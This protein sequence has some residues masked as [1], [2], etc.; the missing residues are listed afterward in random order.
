[1]TNSAA[2]LLLADPK[3][4]GMSREKWTE[5][6]WIW[7]LSIPKSVNP[8]NDM[9]GD[10]CAR[11]QIEP[12]MWFLAG[13][14]GKLVKR[15]CLVPSN[16]AILFPIINSVHLLS[17][18]LSFKSDSDLEA[19][20]RKEADNVTEMNLTIDGLQLS[21]LIKYRIHTRSFDI[22]I[23]EDNICGVKPGESR[24]AAD[25]YWIF[26]RPLS[27]GRHTIEFFGKDLDLFETGVT[28]ELTV[29]NH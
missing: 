12:N 5:K 8:A 22:I 24:A 23:P 27:P 20:V 3:P 28:Y 17:E 26:L 29:R 13:T 4:Y 14:F 6:W 15:A 2:Q 10:Q 16:R 25:G 1:M 11:N 21:E 9:A 19:K 7:L 18:S